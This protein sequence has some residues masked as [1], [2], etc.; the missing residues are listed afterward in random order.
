M[1][2]S[3][4]EWDAICRKCGECC[5]EKLEDEY[6][7]IIYLKKACR[8]LDIHTRKCR[9]F[10]RRLEIN[11]SCVKL[12]EKLVMKLSWLPPN[13]GYRIAGE[14]REEQKRGKRNRKK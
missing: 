6:G 1:N 3:E 5:F 8:Y 10:E 11:R 7:E 12:T 2:S 9:I 4:K 13:C 14:S